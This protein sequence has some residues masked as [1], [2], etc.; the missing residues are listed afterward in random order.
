MDA[1]VS[2]SVAGAG[3]S[4]VAL[5]E[6][7]RTVIGRLAGVLDSITHSMAFERV[8]GIMAQENLGKIAQSLHLLSEAGLDNAEIIELRGLC[9]RL[10]L[11][12]KQLFIERVHLSDASLDRT[13]RAIGEF[14]TM[15]ELMEGALVERDLLERQQ[16]VLEHVILSHSEFA[17]WD[18][19][20][21]EVLL[22]LYVEFPFDVFYALINDG[23]AHVL[24]VYEAG[25]AGQIQRGAQKR[26]ARRAADAMGVSGGVGVKVFNL[27]TGA[28]I[29]SLED[30]PLLSVRV[31]GQTPR[32]GHL[33]GTAFLP[34]GTL[35]VREQSVVR[36]ILTVLMIVLESSRALSRTVDELTHD[37]THDPL[38]GLYNRRHFQTMIEYEIHQAERR[39]QVFSVLM[40]DLDDFKNINDSYGHPVGDT[41]LKG[42]AKAVQGVIRKGDMGTR[43]GGDE[44]AILLAETNRDGAMRVAKKLGN[45]LR[46]RTFQEPGGHT[47]RVTSSIG[48]VCYPE[49]ARSA[50]ELLAAV[51]VAM[52][53]A[54]KMG[55][56]ATCS[57][58]LVSE[59]LHEVQRRHD[60]LED[61]RLALEEKRVIPYFQPIIDCRSGALFASEAMARMVTR[62]NDV[63]AAVRF[64]ETVERH[65]LGHELDD[66][67]VER[68]LSML[69]KAGESQCLFINLAP[70]E[71]QNPDFLT[72]VGALCR[73]FEIA[74]GRLVFEI[75]ARDV[76]VDF[77]TTCSF[78]DQLH[79][80]GFAFAIDDFGGGSGASINYLRK[81]KVEYVKIDGSL[82][83][84]IG[85]SEVNWAL[86]Q[87]FVRLCQDLG[88]HTV[89]KS[90]ESLE[91][92]RTLRLMGVD[93]V[94]G[95][96]PGVPQPTLPL[97][98]DFGL[99]EQTTKQHQDTPQRPA[100]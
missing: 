41:V 31:V 27:D 14:N 20:V 50:T 40:L 44:F 2:V 83:G 39:A 19:F 75:M 26:L 52:Y 25:A 97:A 72:H 74:P 90:V 66:V 13:V 62:D 12:R 37:A 56:D 51:D 17:Q 6:L 49:D 3:N 87:N 92:L 36:S 22:N 7:R 8:S 98:R 82:I 73:Q 1:K 23:N 93:Y 84:S 43:M 33:V 91:T 88:V 34:E 4:P 61:M 54:K 42:V 11:S 15:F 55:K 64:I 77:K 48:V 100:E 5:E 63:I 81:M 68:A 80:E 10:E 95:Y 57:T 76:M 70:Q 53:R 78:I 18:A 58:A 28:K 35:N 79:A 65:G 60:H 67:I 85:E 24:R 71:V 21:R 32:S 94:Q 46:A 99:G 16:R 96:H 59:S 69:G 45:A 47:F 89:G 29:Q 38:T 86:V 30:K 9:E